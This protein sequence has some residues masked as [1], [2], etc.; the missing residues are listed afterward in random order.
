MGKLGVSAGLITRRSEETIQFLLMV[1]EFKI[2]GRNLLGLE[3]LLPLFS[4]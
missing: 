3:V 2:F 1:A 4:S